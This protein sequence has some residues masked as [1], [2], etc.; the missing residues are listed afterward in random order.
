MNNLKL[1]DHFAAL[2]PL[3]EPFMKALSGAL[4]H[5][6]LKRGD[7][8]KQNGQTPMIWYI[9]N[10]LA[11]GYYQDQE[12]K[13]HVTRFWKENQVMLL[14]GGKKNKTAAD[15]IMLLEDS[16]LT[17]L[18][19]SSILYLYH[20]F[21]E[22]PKLSSKII[23]DDRNHGELKSFLCSLPTAQ[24]YMQFQQNFPSGRL[25]LRDIASY[26]EISPG[27]MSAIRRNFN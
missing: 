24:G 25:L 18:S 26:L 17:T 22:A 27:R 2:Y 9:Q 12:G 14:T 19:D 10:G 20:S 5:K 6:Q 21:S 16:H 1:T 13:E 15:R 8:L 23:L 4:I 3:G 11:K 7:I